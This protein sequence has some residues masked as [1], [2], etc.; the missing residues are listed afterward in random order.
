MVRVVTSRM[1]ASIN[2]LVPLLVLF[3]FSGA[4]QSQIAFRSASSSI[5]EGMGVQ[6]SALGAVA[7]GTGATVT[8]GLPAL[9]AGDLLITV[10]QA[11]DLNAVTMPSPNWNL[12]TSGS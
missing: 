12:L 10:I 9:V 4:A 6:H 8:P 3:L 5:N 11:H 7:S 1:R 2:A